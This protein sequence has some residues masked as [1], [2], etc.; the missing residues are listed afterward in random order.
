MIYIKFG[1]RLGNQLFQYAFARYLQK[2][3]Y[4]EDTLVFNFDLVEKQG[5]IE[6][7]WKNSLSD[8]NIISHKYDSKA[9]LN[10][11]Q[12]IGCFVYYFGNKALVRYKNKTDFDVKAQRFLN[13]LGIY[14]LRKTFYVP[15]TQ[16]KYSKNK[17]VRG[18]FEA[19]EYCD[20]V[21][22]ELIKEIRPLEDILPYNVCLY[23]KI[24]SS[25][26][27]C[28]TIR[29][30]DFLKAENKSFNVC[31]EEYFYNGMKYIQKNVKN[32]TFF[33]FSDDIEWV[34][35]N[36]KFPYPVNY[37][38]NNGRDP[39][40]E[41]LRLMSSCK[42][43]VISNSTFSWWA[44]YLSLFENKIVVAPKTWRLREECSGLYLNN[45]V[46]LNNIKEDRGIS[47]ED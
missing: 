35:E 39:V 10:L 4:P 27:V 24:L 32:A 16:N 29:R 36:M 14:S 47:S 17:Y 31:D 43:F 1:G 21:R 18:R 38:N 20:Y 28:I 40:W 42:H 33:V 19:H 30:G 6:Q 44:Q 2:K 25:D 15:V 8:F 9:R 23:Q 11:F 12:L 13:N 5:T 3:Y 7:G 46:L 45:F 34:R 22:A 41:K 26:S 37:E